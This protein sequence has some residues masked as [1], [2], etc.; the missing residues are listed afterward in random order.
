[1]RRMF[2]ADDGAPDGAWEFFRVGSTKMP[3]QRA[4]RQSAGNFFSS[5]ARWVKV[6]PDAVV[7]RSLKIANSRC[8]GHSSGVK[9]LK[10]PTESQINAFIREFANDSERV[11]V[12]AGVSQVDS[13]LTELL[14][15]RL[16][17]SRRKDDE[18][19]APDRFGK[20]IRQN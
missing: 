7:Q 14:R 17:P 12:V 6:S 10:H 11:L 3:R 16:L 8:I 1:M 9:P 13:I 20:Y 19:F 4:E 15:M 2:C 18:L 5:V